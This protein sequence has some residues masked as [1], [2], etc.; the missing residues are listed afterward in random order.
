MAPFLRELEAVFAWLLTASWQASVLALFVFSIQGIFGSRLNPRWR[1]ALWLLVLVRLV[2]PALPESALSLFQFAPPPPA[3]IVVPVTEPLFVP[4]PLPLFPIDA[5]HRAPGYPFSFYSLLAVAWLA[6]VVVFL[7]LTWRVNRRFARQVGT[8]PEIADP[9]ILTLFAE[10][11]AELGVHRSIRLIENG[12]VQ[13][14]SIM[15]LFAPTLLLPVDVRGKFDARELRFIFLHELAHLKRGDVIVQMLLAVLQILHWFNPVLWFAFR[16]MRIDREPATDALVLSHTGEAEKERYGLMLIKLLE[17][18]NQRHALPT[19]VGILEDKDQFKRR[20]SLIA[21]FTRGAYGWSLLGL[22]LIAILAIVGLTKGRHADHVIDQ[23]LPAVIDLKPFYTRAFLPDGSDSMFHGYAGRQVIDGLP[24]DI[25]GKIAL[26][27]KENADRNRD[28][29]NEISGI[30]IGHKFDELH[31]VH[32][33]EWREYYGCPVATVR[34]HYAD[35]TRYDFPIR[36]DF[37]VND[38]SRLFTE[39]AEIIA[40]PDTKIIWRGAGSAEGTGRLFKS[41]LRN[42]F[43]EKLVESMDLIST[44]SGCT[45]V[46]IA[47]TVAQSD[48]QRAVTAPMPLLTGRD[49]DGTLNVRVI[50]A[51]TGAPIAGAKVYPAMTIGDISLVADNVLTSSD[52]IAPVKYPK[53]DTKDL[54]LKVAKAGYLT[55][56]DKWQNGWDTGSIPPEFTCQLTAGR[57]PI[58]DARLVMGHWTRGPGLADNVDVTRSMRLILTPKMGPPPFPPEADTPEKKQ[59]W[60]QDWLPTDAGR[61]FDEMRRRGR[62]LVIKADGTFVGQA[63]APGDYILYAVF[64]NQSQITAQIQNTAV[65]VPANP[66]ND[67]DAPVDLGSVVVSGAQPHVD[68]TPVQPSSGDASGKTTTASPNPNTDASTQMVQAVEKGDAVALQKLIDQGGDPSKLE[69]RGQPLIFSAG[70]ADIAEILLKHG[71]DPNARNKQK[72]AA[73]PYLLRNKGNGATDIARVLLEHG[74]D[75][76]IRSGEIGETPL[77]DARTGAAVDLLVEHGADVRLKTTTGTTVLD[78]AS[79]Q[80]L[81]Y[82]Q[83][84]LRHGVSFDAKTDGAT[85]LLRASWTSNLPMMKEMI[86]R[87]VDPNVEGMW[88]MVHG[89][90]MRMLPLTAAAVDNQLQAAKFLVAHGAK[91]DDQMITAMH[92]GNNA[93]VKLFWESGVRSVSELC[94]AVSQKAPVADLQ[95]LLDEGVPADPP[96]DKKITPLGEAARLGSMDAVQLLVAHRADV[97]SGG[98]INPKFP[99]MT[100]MSP[101]WLA[102][103]EGQ[104]EVVTYLLQQGAKPE[105]EALWQAAENSYP[106]NEQRSKDHF[107]KTVRILIDAGAARNVTPEM[108]GTILA[109]SLGTRQGPPNATVLKMLLDAGLSPEAPMPYIVENGEKPNSVI[110]Y[111]RDYYQK[112]KDDPNRGSMVTDLKPLLDLMA[113]ADKHAS[114][115]TVPVSAPNTPEPTD[116]T[117][118]SLAEKV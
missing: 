96:E 47:A 46:L 2:L 45:Y 67:P 106:Y 16:R 64:V 69:D 5:P 72:D 109:S 91:A 112:F 62:L 40:D 39:D 26:F 56:E 114:T 83:A 100:R 95:K 97:N 78:M 49:F 7:V 101:L 21:K 89:K 87:G 59:K 9:E 103:G 111:Y 55:N 66:G 60:M 80:P 3:A 52:G 11:Q 18:F 86:D 4:A 82:F 98:P 77:M 74:A 94:Y 117:A 105:P 29:P 118:S 8:S 24:F 53:A 14:P 23:T 76:N 90:P 13:S 63:V 20:F 71:A 108:A 92:N 1:Y 115:D 116:K 93:I 99:Q 102:A 79:N 68:A 48:A 34:L 31:L 25:D 65:T 88:A 19:L 41:V 61:K 42:P 84:L 54:R 33:V 44:R 43:P 107:E 75:P 81:D 35:G 73:L 6:G 28:Y 22:V 51:A 38:W 36:F 30:K 27:G 32:A 70:N 57:D 113:A 12:Q 58:L 85:L 110:A 17:H 37:Q 15:G 50:D 104:D 10:A